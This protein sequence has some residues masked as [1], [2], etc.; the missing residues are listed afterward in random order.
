M[1]KTTTSAF[2]PDYMGP[3]AHP[4]DDLVFVFSGFEIEMEFFEQ[5]KD[6]DEDVARCELTDMAEKICIDKT[7]VSFKGTKFR[8]TFIKEDG[9]N[10][11]CDFVWKARKRKSATDHIMLR[12]AF[13]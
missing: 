8:D 13:E 7:Y 4:G 3:P 1:S 2:D 9:W 11:L 6:F 10:M 12:K 5:D